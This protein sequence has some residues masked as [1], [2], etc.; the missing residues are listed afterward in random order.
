LKKNLITGVGYVLRNFDIV[1]KAKE[2]IGNLSCTW[3]WS[4]FHSAVE[5]VGKGIIITYEGNKLTIDRGSKKETYISDIDPIKYLI[6]SIVC[7]AC[8][9]N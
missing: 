1:D 8:S 9:T 5:I 3:L 7:V 6:I 2:I 4:G